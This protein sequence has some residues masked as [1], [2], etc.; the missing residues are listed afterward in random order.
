VQ[1][2]SEVERTEAA[3]G[4]RRAEPG[5]VRVRHPA[6]V[7]RTRCQTKRTP[8]ALKKSREINSHTRYLS[9]W[10]YKRPVTP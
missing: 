3:R 9:R 7:I 5:P 4:R 8:V 1:S 2:L 6:E 10:R